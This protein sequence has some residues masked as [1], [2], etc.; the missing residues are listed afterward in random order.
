MVGSGNDIRRNRLLG[1]ILATRFEM[2]LYIPVLEGEAA[3]GAALLAAFGIGEFAGLDSAA[4]MLKYSESVNPII[5]KWFV[6]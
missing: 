3:T 4:G 2:P 1:E 5:H 6:P